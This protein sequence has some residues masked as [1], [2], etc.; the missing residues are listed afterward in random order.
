MDNIENNN[1]V[2]VIYKKLKKDL[3]KKGFINLNH[4]V[5]NTNEDLVEIASIFRDQRYETFRVVYMNKNKIVGY[6]SISTKTPNSVALY[7]VSKDGKKNMEKCYYKV[8][9]RMQRL[10]ADGYY[11]VH[12][13]PSDNA[14]ASK[15]DIKCTEEYVKHVDGFKG[16][17]IVNGT[18]YAWIEVDSLGNVISNDYIPINKMSLAKTNFELKTKNIFDMKIKSRSDF[19]NVMHNIKNSKDY[20]IAILSDSQGGI[21]MVLDIPNRMLNMRV[22][23]LNGYFKNLARM[24]GVTRVFF[25][26]TNESTYEKAQEH[27][28]IGTFKDSFY[29][30]D[31]ISDTINVL[32]KSDIDDSMDLFNTNLKY[33]DSTVEENKKEYEFNIHDSK[34]IDLGYDP[35]FDKYL[36]QELPKVD[37]KHLR[38]LHKKVGLPP[39]V[40][41]IGKEL[42]NLQKEVEG[43]IEVIPYYDEK[44]ILLVCNDEG[45][46]DNRPP[47][48]LLGD[49]DYIA[50]DFFLV[51]DDY[52]NAG[53]KSLTREQII[54]L[55]DDLMSISFKYIKN[56]DDEER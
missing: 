8:K 19:V 46:L 32:R 35:E 15:S 47:N 3:N 24:N 36:P 45:K 1:N 28:L 26:T 39:E 4:R 13:H 16:H 2:K 30:N 37:E 23:Q 49:Y 14:R 18:S 20:S 12:N 25:A 50:G 27:H 17:L 6:E 7:K 53:F 43:L 29:Y 22:E 21:R 31:E 5:V 42:E 9:D 54:R 51:G 55:R 38:I 11:M 41:I 34:Y 33:N 48:I 52:E 44:D 40:K 10:N 56:K